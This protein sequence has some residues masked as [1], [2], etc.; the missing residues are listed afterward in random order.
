[1]KKALKYYRNNF[2]IRN[3]T[4]VIETGRE[5]KLARKQRKL[6]DARE[7]TLR[8]K[9]FNEIVNN[10]MSMV[11]HDRSNCGSVMGGDLN[12]ALNIR[13]M[14]MQY[15]WNPQEPEVADKSLWMFLPLHIAKMCRQGR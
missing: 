14:Y 3:N 13:G 15:V 10:E 6:T 12:D 9:A 4:S 7:E 11:I 1:M 8:H 2:L 5:E